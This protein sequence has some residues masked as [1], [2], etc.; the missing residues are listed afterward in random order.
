MCRSFVS[1]FRELGIE[2]G[3]SYGITM[4]LHRFRP[5][6][7]G[8]PRVSF[9][10]WVLGNWLAEFGCFQRATFVQPMADPADNF[11]FS[12][13]GRTIYHDFDYRNVLQTILISDCYLIGPYRPCWYSSGIFL[14]KLKAKSFP[15][16]HWPGA[17]SSLRR[18][19]RTKAR[20][21]YLP[22][23]MR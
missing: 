21:T 10:T 1:F 4:P 12:H 5:L 11:Q 8:F 20:R 7:C 15:S 18:W 13:C 19:F 17:I 14:V 6:L 2:V 3:H 23:G 22:L 16:I 9:F